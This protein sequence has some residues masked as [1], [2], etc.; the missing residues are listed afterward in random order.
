MGF[1]PLALID[2][3]YILI[4][5]GIFLVA[6]EVLKIFKRMGRKEK[7]LKSQQMNN[8]NP[9]QMQRVDL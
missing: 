5:V 4:S 8:E 6:Y 1:A 9:T 2:W 3:F 7:K